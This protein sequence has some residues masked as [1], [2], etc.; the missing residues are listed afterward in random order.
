M[1]RRVIV[2]SSVAAVSTEAGENTVMIDKEGVTMKKGYYDENDFTN[3]CARKKLDAYC[4][5][6]AMAEKVAWLFTDP[7]TETAAPLSRKEIIDSLLPP[8][9]ND[10]KHKQGDDEV[11]LWMKKQIDEIEKFIGPA[12]SSKRYLEIATINPSFVV[13]KLLMKRHADSS[14]SAVPIKRLMVDKLPAI[15]QVALPCCAVDDVALCHVR[16]MTFDN[17][18]GKRFIVHTKSMYMTEIANVITDNFA[19]QG[20]SLS[21]IVLPYALVY[22]LSFFDKEIALVLPRIGHKQQFVSLR[23]RQTLLSMDDTAPGAFSNVEN[24][25]EELAGSLIKFKCV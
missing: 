22:L 3:L 24:S 18:V 8:D 14:T 15:P 10:K 9:C 23:T 2:T 7:T 11:T 25:I 4:R 17:V 19:S 1:V 5:S 16:A 13:G 6:K 21:K 12:S 20:F